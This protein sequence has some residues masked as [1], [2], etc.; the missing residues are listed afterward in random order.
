MTNLDFGGSRPGETQLFTVGL[1]QTADD[2]EYI[3]EQ[4]AVDFNALPDGD[5]IEELDD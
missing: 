1:R 5:W 2:A 3:G 4:Q